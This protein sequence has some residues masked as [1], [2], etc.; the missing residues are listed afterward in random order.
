MQ[1]KRKIGWLTGLLI[2]G[3]VLFLFVGVE[4]SYF[5]YAMKNRIP[6]VF[7]MLLSA[8]C[9]GG[10]TVVFQTISNNHIL[11][12]SIL[13]LDSLYVLVQ[14]FIVFVLGSTSPLIV[15]KQYNF[16]IALTAMI[17]ASVA[18]YKVLFERGKGDVMFL[19]LVGMIFGTLF[20]SL[21]SFMQRVIDPNEF[22]AL[23]NNLF[24]SFNNI[25]TSILT[26]AIIIMLLLIPFVWDDL[27]YLDVMTLGRD[28]AINLGVDYDRIVKK[29]IV[30][31]TILI[32]ISTALIGPITFLGL[33]VVNV[34]RQILKTYKH[35]Y[36]ILGSM[37]LGGITLLYGQLIVE[38]VLGFTT[39]LSVVVN[40][41]GGL[42]FIYL[43][44]K[45]SKQT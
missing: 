16:M 2:V 27:K 39:T 1:A 45:E 11:T 26:I 20:G 5:D 4:W 3:I 41:I 6:K 8:F 44:L 42:Y 13:G 21:S 18:L 43:L 12:P 25:H 38:Q 24:A 23:Q 22:L 37:M 17:F 31:V 19:L 10:A 32:S 34:A 40:L 35:S 30:V 15:N 33:L 7:A 28:H 9:I 36:L 29:L 14:T